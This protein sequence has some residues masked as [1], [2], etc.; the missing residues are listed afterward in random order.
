MVL[1]LDPRDS[2]AW[3]E[4]GSSLVS[5]GRT[6]EA[7]D[8][9]D[10]ALTIQPGN[11]LRWLCKAEAELRT[12]RKQEAVYS[13]QQAIRVASVEESSLVRVARRRLQELGS[14]SPS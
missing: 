2:M 8:C 4:K 3:D 7:I 1:K 6:E 13:F 10:R 9:Y 14:E 12:G 11:P 5:L